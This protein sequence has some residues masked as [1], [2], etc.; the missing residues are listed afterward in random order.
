MPPAKITLSPAGNLRLRVVP[1]DGAESYD[2]Q[3]RNS[4][5]REWGFLRTITSER[6]LWLGP[7]NRLNGS[8]EVR[9]RAVGPGGAHSAWSPPQKVEAA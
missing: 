3:C 2:V 5:K 6:Q 4:R 9:V 7:F 1:V 8:E